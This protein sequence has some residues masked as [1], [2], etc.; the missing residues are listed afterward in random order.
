MCD[1]CDRAVEEVVE[2]MR[3]TSPSYVEEHHHLQKLLD[4]LMPVD[5]E[6][7]NELDGDWERNRNDF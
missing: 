1:I 3:K 5:P 6:P 4:T 7:S 2:R